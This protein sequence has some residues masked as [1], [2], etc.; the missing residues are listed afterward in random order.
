MTEPLNVVTPPSVGSGKSTTEFFKLLALLS[1][2]PTGFNTFT[3]GCSGQHNPSL[4]PVLLTWCQ[5]C[6]SNSSW[7]QNYY[8]NSGYLDKV[9][10]FETEVWVSCDFSIVF[11]FPHG[12]PLYEKRVVFDVGESL[13]FNWNL[14]L[15]NVRVLLN[16]SQN[17]HMAISKSQQHL[18]HIQKLKTN[19]FM[20]NNTSISNKMNCISLGQIQTMEHVLNKD[21]SSDIWM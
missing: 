13:T 12:W 9:F 1:F 20:V 19:T 8:V 16:L 5:H 7:K 17:S 21:D 6:Y 3:I 14:L 18:D 2:D 4:C 11:S 15:C 10:D